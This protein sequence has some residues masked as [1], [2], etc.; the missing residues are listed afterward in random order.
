[1]SEKN[2]P[3]AVAEQ[4]DGTP[5]VKKT[6]SVDTIHNDEA[7]TVLANY[8]GE[9]TWTDAEEKKLRRKIDWRLMTVLCITYS[10]Q[11]YDKAMLS[12]AVCLLLSK[13]SPSEQKNV[14]SCSR[15]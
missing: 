8:D 13:D 1:M 14:T 4:T 9:Q 3:T 11:Y 5:E 2:E 6:I 7:L 10:L 12:Q 15:Y